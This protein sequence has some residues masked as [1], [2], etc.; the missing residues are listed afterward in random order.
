MR[1]PVM[2]LLMALPTTVPTTTSPKVGGAATTT[3]AG[4]KPTGA[5][6]TG[7]ATGAGGATIVVLL[8]TVVLVVLLAAGARGGAFRATPAV[9]PMRPP[10]RAAW[11]SKGTSSKAKAATSELGLEKR[12]RPVKQTKLIVLVQ[13]N[14][15]MILLQKHS[16]TFKFT[17]TRKAFHFNSQPPWTKR[18]HLHVLR[19][20][21]LP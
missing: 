6:T 18:L 20:A 17:S 10:E 5:A 11:A 1:P 7:G 19:C 2:A 4:A 13:S 8:I 3:G 16:K 9:P 21:S 14:V 15:P 12:G